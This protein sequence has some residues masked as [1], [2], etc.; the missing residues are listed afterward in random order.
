LK[1]RINILIT[2][3]Y[4]ILTVLYG[5]SLLSQNHL[6]EIKSDKTYFKP[7]IFKQIL[8]LRSE[9][10]GT[11]IANTREKASK[12]ANSLK[13]SADT[14]NK[15]SRIWSQ[16]DTYNI[17]VRLAE[18]DVNI[19]LG[20]YNMLGKEVLKIYSGKANAKESIYTFTTADLPN[21]VYFCVLQGPNFRNAEKFIVSKSR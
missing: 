2:L 19:Q 1:N 11:V 7:N 20:A 3:F 17:R 6:N 9:S 14:L 13:T 16:G 8:R 18:T 5:G 15:I 21:G 12:E 10:N 4:T